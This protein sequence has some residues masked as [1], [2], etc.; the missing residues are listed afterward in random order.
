MAPRRIVVFAEKSTGKTALAVG[1][2]TVA[3]QRGK[4]VL[5]V[6]LDPRA[7]ATEELGVQLAPDQLTVNDI[8]YIHEN[9]GDP[10]GTARE[11]IV[12]AGPEWPKLI[13]VLPSERALANREADTTSG[14]EQRLGDSLEDGVADAYDYVIFDVRQA[15]GGKVSTVALRT[16]DEALITATLTK[17]G[18]KGAVGARQSIKEITERGI[19]RNL[20][21][22]GVVPSMVSLTT[23]PDKRRIPA[24]TLARGDAEKRR[25]PADT[26]ARG[27]LEDLRD[28]FGDL[29]WD[30]I[31]IPLRVVRAKVEAAS[32]PLNHP[33]ALKEDK[34]GAEALLKAYGDVLDRIDKA[35]V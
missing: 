27:I 6:D 7:S 28:E 22:L 17:Q 5:V 9:A 4:R 31:L 16:G 32:I 21:I 14:M 20:R 23:D 3:A 13:S 15:T 25:I 35:G 26:L 12:P 33:L 30:D 18:F 24:G 10:W 8:L 1:L 11:V 19:N 29:L 34:S 2:A